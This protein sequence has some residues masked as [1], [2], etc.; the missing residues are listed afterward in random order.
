MPKSIIG[1]DDDILEKGLKED[2]TLDTL[3]NEYIKKILNK[4]RDH[5]TK[6]SRILGIDRRTLYRKIKRYHLDK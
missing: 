3:E 5:R 6:A 1:G 2:L 4:T